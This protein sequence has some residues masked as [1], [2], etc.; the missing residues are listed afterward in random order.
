MTSNPQRILVFQQNGIGTPKIEGIRQYGG[1]DFMISVVSIDSGLP[2][3]LDDTDGFLPE[4][5]EADLVLDFLTH[6]D[7]SLDLCAR[8]RDLSI[9]VVALEKD[10]NVNV[11]ATGQSDRT[12]R[13]LSRYVFQV[14]ISGVQ[15]H[16]V[17]KLHMTI[18][19]P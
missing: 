10:W 12:I 11:Q 8:C 9:P 6:P 15:S 7:L 5:I 13:Y 14:A 4:T 2:A 3:V 19:R 17:A 1:D 18:L 16:F